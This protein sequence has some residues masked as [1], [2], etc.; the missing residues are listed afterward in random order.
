MRKRRRMRRG[1]EAHVIVLFIS[2]FLALLSPAR[3]GEKLKRL[4]ERLKEE[5]MST[6]HESISFSP[7]PL[8]EMTSVEKP[9]ENSFFRPLQE[10]TNVFFISI[11][12][13]GARVI[14]QILRRM[15]R[16]RKLKTAHPSDFK[17]GE[18]LLRKD[19]NVFYKRVAYKKIAN[20][21]PIR[22]PCFVTL[23]RTTHAR[24]LSQYRRFITHYL[25]N[26]VRDGNGPGVG[27]REDDDTTSAHHG[28]WLE[29]FLKQ[30]PRTI[31]VHSRLRYIGQWSIFAD[32]PTQATTVLR[33]KAILIGFTES[34]EEFLVML[35]HRLAFSDVRPLLY[36]DLRPRSTEAVRG[37]SDR[38]PALSLSHHHHYHSHAGGLSSFASSSFIDSKLQARLDALPGLSDDKKFID[39]AKYLYFGQRAA[40]GE[41]TLR[42]ETTQLRNLLESLHEECRTHASIL[43]D[44]QL[45]K[46]GNIPINMPGSHQL[47]SILPPRLRNNERRRLRR[48]K[49]TGEMRRRKRTSTQNWKVLDA[50]NSARKHLKGEPLPQCETKEKSGLVVNCEK[51]PANERLEWS[52]QCML[53]KYDTCARNPQIRRN[54]CGEI[55]TWVA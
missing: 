11:E 34:M 37:A 6:R 42:H 36:A 7:S 21:S 3:G 55:Q 14:E 30:D 8:K 4:R 31:R 15:V 5:S 41:R 26:V 12:H 16:E 17:G 38:A 52:I 28:Q 23:L 48:T 18:A 25:P 50:A 51:A 13:N 10:K 33:S 19:L 46:E 27:L 32:T 35:Q 53:H 45:N 1:S 2:C 9:I 40:F 24:A 20:I 43:T 54:K 22:N 49:K 44:K 39:A 47:A 29:L